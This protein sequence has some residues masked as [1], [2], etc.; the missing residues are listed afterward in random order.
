MQWQCSRCILDSEK[1]EPIDYSH[2]AMLIE[3]CRV[4]KELNEPDDDPCRP[5]SIEEEIRFSKVRKKCELKREARERKAL[6]ATDFHTGSH[7][8]KDHARCNATDRASSSCKA[9]GGFDEDIS[10]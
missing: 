7:A 10:A 9:G 8:D 2:R 1:N 5:F 6:A 4:C 3:A